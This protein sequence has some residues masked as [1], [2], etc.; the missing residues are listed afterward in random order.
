VRV[1]LADSTETRTGVN[2][3]LENLQQIIGGY[4]R[5]VPGHPEAFCDEDGMMK[6]LPWN[7]VA[8]NLL[9]LTLVGPVVILTEDE[10]A[11]WNDDADADD[12]YDEE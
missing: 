6:E 10:L 7:K 2:P 1:I 8:S 9:G 5:Q 3:S 12:F 4:I 11:Q